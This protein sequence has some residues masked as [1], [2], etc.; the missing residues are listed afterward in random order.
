M[1]YMPIEE[2]KER[3]YLQEANRLFFHPIGLALVVSR[4]EDGSMELC[5]IQ[6]CRDDPEGMIFGDYDEE[7]ADRVWDEKMAKMDARIALGCCTKMGIQAEDYM[8]AQCK[9]TE[10]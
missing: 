8:E 6:D 5:G 4:D 7:K 3:G 10:Q 9:N 1:K 2:F